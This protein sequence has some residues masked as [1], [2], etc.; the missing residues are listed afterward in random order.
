MAAI[1]DYSSVGGRAKVFGNAQIYERAQ[2]SDTAQVYGKARIGGSAKIQGKAKISGTAHIIG[3]TWDGSE[4]EVT[5]GYWYSPQEYLEE[6]RPK[7]QTTRTQGYS[8]TPGSSRAP[9]DTPPVTP[10]Y[11]PV[12]SSEKPSGMTPYLKRFY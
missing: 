7:S 9:E 2:I 3:G 4:G 6:K 1:L 12:P 5:S 8:R 11:M 10:W